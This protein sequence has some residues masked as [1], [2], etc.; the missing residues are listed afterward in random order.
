M[1]I[2]LTVYFNIKWN[3]TGWWSHCS[4]LSRNRAKE[5][6]KYSSFLINSVKLTI[7]DSKCR[8]NDYEY[9]SWHTT[10]KKCESNYCMWHHRCS[11]Q[12]NIL[13]AIRGL[14][15]LQ[16]HLYFQTSFW[17]YSSFPRSRKRRW[18]IIQLVTIHF[19]TGGSRTEKKD[20]GNV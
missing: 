20:K 9:N 17:L 14:S 5:E 3:Y 15:K 2:E 12:L 13:K 7:P 11:R 16:R 1:F 10:T 18:N 4:E 19:Q 8:G 6:R